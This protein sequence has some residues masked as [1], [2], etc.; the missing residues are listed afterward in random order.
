MDSVLSER[1]NKVNEIFFIEYFNS[2][3]QDLRKANIK[4]EI[5]IKQKPCDEICNKNLEESILQCNIYVKEGEFQ[6]GL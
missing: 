1:V 6:A 4:L 2:V 3:S 5:T